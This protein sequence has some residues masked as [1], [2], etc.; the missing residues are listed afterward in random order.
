MIFASG[1]SSPDA[2]LLLPI[3]EVAQI[4]GLSKTSIYRAVHR[5][6]IRA[7]RIGR[8]LLVPRS[9]IQGLIDGS[10][11]DLF[12]NGGGGPSGEAK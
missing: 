9:T 10:I 6:Q 7:V 3:R 2:R 11:C 1:G 12:G 8:R 4:T 5:R